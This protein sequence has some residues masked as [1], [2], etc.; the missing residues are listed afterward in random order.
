M[1]KPLPLPHLSLVS[2][3]A[4]ADEQ[5]RYGP[6]G[7]PPQ[8]AALVRS[9]DRHRQQSSPGLASLRDLRP[10]LE[11]VAALGP[12]GVRR[13]STGEGVA[14]GHPDRIGLRATQ[15]SKGNLLVSL[16]LLRGVLQRNS[17][18]ARGSK[19][20]LLVILQVICGVFQ[21][22]SVLTHGRCHNLLVRTQLLGSE[23]Q[24]QAV[25]PHCCEHH[26]PVASQ[27]LVGI[28][29]R[30]TIPMYGSKHH[31]TITTKSHRNVSHA[32]KMP[33]RCSSNGVGAY[34]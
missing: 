27:I 25:L 13:P 7:V 6:G 32:G 4:Y 24:G 20:H 22:R 15:G 23:L 26:L 3:G 12:Q 16:Q 1:P 9:A 19:H 14:A 29:Q 34:R 18:P 10:G 11:A 2:R 17:L 31:R 30:T 28:L 21:C 8:G 33:G 5:L